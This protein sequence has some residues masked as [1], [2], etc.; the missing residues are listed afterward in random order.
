MKEKIAIIG[1][2]HWGLTLGDVLGNN[3][4][5]VLAYVRDENNALE[6]NNNHTMKKY[7][8][9]YKLSPSIKA[10]TNIE[11]AFNLANVIVISLP[12]ITICDTVL[13]LC[14]KYKDKTFV[15]TSKGLYKGKSISSYFYDVIPD[16]K[17]AVLSGPSFAIEV[18]K[19]RPTAVV[20]ASSCERIAKKIQLLFNNNYFRVY[21]SNDVIGT[22]YLG[23]I[24]NVFAIICGMIDNANLGPNARSA[25]ISRGINEMRH[26][27]SAVGGNKTSLYGL[28]GLGDIILTCTSILS[29]NYQYGSYYYDKEKL[30]EINGTV[31]GVN[32]L[33]EIYNLSRE[34][35]IDTPIIC[36]L[37]R[38]VFE[39]SSIEKE[40]DSLM[41]RE[42]KAE[43]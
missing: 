24:K 40:I 11:E 34:K 38:I 2:G 31:E 27:I 1:S 9:D 10:I 19:K 4:N 43:D 22:E 7:F 35:S 15:L 33:K 25:V 13:E 41:T 28:T 37:Y 30:K 17:L 23:A 20:V 26:I 14:K 12:V 29:R 42:L 16:V 36:S 8:G 18:I 32:T 5:E 39:N 3:N 6:I 21:T